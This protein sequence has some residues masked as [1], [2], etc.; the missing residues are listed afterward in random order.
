MPLSALRKT[1][2]AKWILAPRLIA[3]LPLFVFGS[4]HLSP[5]PLEFCT[6]CTKYFRDSVQL[7]ESQFITP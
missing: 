6:I 1:T 3:A 2:L 7:F 5:L 4:F